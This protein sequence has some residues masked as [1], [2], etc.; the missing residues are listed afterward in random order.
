MHARSLYTSKYASSP[1]V[2]NVCV[3]L[4][5]FSRRNKGDPDITSKADEVTSLSQVMR[6]QLS[7]LTRISIHVTAAANHV[8]L[9]HSDPTQ[10]N[11]RPMC[12][13][14]STFSTQW[15]I[16]GV[17]GS[18]LCI[19][20]ARDAPDGRESRRGKKFSCLLFCL[21]FPVAHGHHDVHSGEFCCV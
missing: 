11:P 21:Y 9:F 19:W 17:Q 16:L 1:Q 5:L 18:I 10:L 4:F 13:R 2:A 15:S 3:P 20:D 8:E 12:G 7:T 6:R 14:R